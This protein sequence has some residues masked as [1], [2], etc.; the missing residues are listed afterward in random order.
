MGTSSAT[1]GSTSTVLRPRLLQRPRI[2]SLYLQER[3]R[4]NWLA[5]SPLLPVTEHLLNMVSPLLLP[6]SLRPK[7]P[8]EDT[9]LPPTLPNT[10]NTLMPLLQTEITQTTKNL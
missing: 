6:P 4:P 2:A 3:L 10:P 9:G 5:R 1:G 8:L 7:R